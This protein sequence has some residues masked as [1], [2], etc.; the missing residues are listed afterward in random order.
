MRV[1]K[2]EGVGGEKTPTAR[3]WGEGKGGRQE[4]KGQPREREKVPTKKLTDLTIRTSACMHQSPAVA[5]VPGNVALA[6]CRSRWS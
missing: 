1:S 4:K 3:V 5:V 2:W 6:R